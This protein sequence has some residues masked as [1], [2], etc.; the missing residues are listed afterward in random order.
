MRP[1]RLP[2]LF[3]VSGENAAHRVA[4]VWQEDDGQYREGV[5]IPRRD[6]GSL[7][8]HLAGGRVFPGEHHRAHF[9]VLEDPQGLSLSMESYD[10][11]VTV[12]VRGRF[13]GTL[14]ET[15]CF[16]SVSE[17]SGFFEPGALGYSVTGTPGRLDGLKLQTQEWRV[18]PL[19][20][21]EVYSSYFADQR[22]FPTGAVTFDCALAMRDVRHEWHN[23]EDLYV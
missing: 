14:P 13:G 17:A 18:E 1:R 15:S 10:Q 3:G 9:A 12:R 4:V 22:L 19:E 21:E 7:L 8:N 11:A 16:A 5:F 6:T 2:A 23:A 20:V